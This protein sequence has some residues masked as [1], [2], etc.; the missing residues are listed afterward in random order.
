[1][2]FRIV[3]LLLGGLLV[4]GCP[5]G[6]DDGDDDTDIDCSPC[7]GDFGIE[8]STDLDDVERCASIEGDLR[9][10]GQDWLTSIDLPC[11]TTVGGN[12]IILSNGCL[13]YVEAEAFA[14]SIHVNG[15]VAV[16]GNGANYPCP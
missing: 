5:S 8:N 1:M 14:A 4:L 13:S 3:V 11:L 10:V 16:W 7:D 9:I 2:R 6:G 15:D 12:L